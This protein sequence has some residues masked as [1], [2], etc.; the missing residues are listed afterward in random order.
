MSRFRNWIRDLDKEVTYGV[1][2][3]NSGVMRDYQVRQL[4]KELL[5][6]RLPD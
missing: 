6:G 4:G 3:L 2:L 5:G 1:N